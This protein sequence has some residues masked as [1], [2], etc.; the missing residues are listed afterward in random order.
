MNSGTTEQMLSAVLESGSMAT[1][2]TIELFN[3]ADFSSERACTLL[4]QLVDRAPQLERISIDMQ[5]GKRKVEVELKLDQTE[6][7]GEPGLIKVIT[8]GKRDDVIVEV[9]TSRTTKVKF[10]LF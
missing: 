6:S 5:Q 3:T 9:S 2:K 8:K 4:A 10:S 7:G 1:I